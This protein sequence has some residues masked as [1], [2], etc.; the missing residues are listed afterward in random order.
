MESES[1]YVPLQSRASRVTRASRGASDDS[2]ESRRA[3]QPTPA[4]AVYGHHSA[5]I[6]GN[7]WLVFAAAAGGSRDGGE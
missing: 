6:I 5:P 2:S 4:V 3:A 1:T 7:Q